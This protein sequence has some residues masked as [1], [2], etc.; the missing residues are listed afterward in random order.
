MPNDR[1][2]A[3][4][5]KSDPA[6]LLSDNPERAKAKIQSSTTA[7]S[8]EW[9]AVIKSHFRVAEATTADEE[10][11]DEL[12]RLK[13]AHIAGKAVMGDF[14]RT[15]SELTE[16]FLNSFQAEHQKI[17]DDD[18]QGALRYNADTAERNA[19]KILREIKS[20]TGF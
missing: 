20:V 4:T 10:A 3:L 8:G 1:T 13:V 14:K 12:R 15:W 6:F 11:L 17:N 7:R 9:N 2:Q 16:Q 5:S 19:E 18:V